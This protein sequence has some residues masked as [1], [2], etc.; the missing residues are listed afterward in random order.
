MDLPSSR[1]TVE[2]L[3]S[4]VQSL[5]GGGIA[6]A[7]MSVLPAESLAGNQ[8]QVV[9]DG[10]GHELGRRLTGSA[11]KDVKGPFRLDQLIAVLQALI[12][13][14]SFPPVSFDDAGQVAIP[15]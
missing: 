9:V 7:K 4:P 11:G 5:V 8:Q 1:Q 2:D 10:L 15:G 14:I 3:D 13:P 12:N 6:D